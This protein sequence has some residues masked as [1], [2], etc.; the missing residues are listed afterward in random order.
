MQPT[1]R[2]ARAAGF[3]YVLTGIT[4]AFSLLYV[5]QTLIVPG[6]AT[7]TANNTLA[8]EMLFRIG[9]VSGL[10]S[11]TAF[12]FLVRLCTAYSMGSARHMRR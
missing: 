2:T 9:I 5:P 11:G 4:G 1:N 7:A 8:S 3:L 12:I 6:N 10:I